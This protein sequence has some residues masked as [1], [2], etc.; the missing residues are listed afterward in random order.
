MRT[1][2]L[3]LRKRYYLHHL[4][5]KRPP[6]PILNHVQNWNHL[7]LGQ[8]LREAEFVVLDTET[9]GLRA[10][11]GDRIVSLSALRVRDGRI[12]LSDTFHQLVNPNRDIPGETVIV[13]EILPRMVEGKPTLDE[14]L[15]GFVEYIGHAILVAHHAWLDMSFLNRE[16][17]RLYGFSLRNMVVDTVSLDQSLAVMKTPAPLRSKIKLD[18][19]LGALAERYHVSL[20]QRHSSFGDALATAQIFQHMVKQA[21]KMGISTL[22]GLLRMALN[23]PALIGVP[24]PEVSPM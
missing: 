10:R 2:W 4:R 6:A 7:D 22:K 21:E 18:S 5:R 14:I 17:T 24:E 9:T 1:I 3:E 12:D 13:H 11:K 16:I 20:D 23:P 8:S 15:P 19:S